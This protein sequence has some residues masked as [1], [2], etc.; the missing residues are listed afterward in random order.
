MSLHLSEK[1]LENPDVLANKLITL[2][3][4][5]VRKHFYSSS[6]EKEDLVSIGVLKALSMINDG[7]F[8]IIVYGFCQG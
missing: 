7:N 3:E 8:A 4:I 1:D 5:V 2:A 6:H